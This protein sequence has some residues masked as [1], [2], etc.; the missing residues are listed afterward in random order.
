MSSHDVKAE[1][2]VILKALK[3][4]IRLSHCFGTLSLMNTKEKIQTV[5]FPSIYLKNQSLS[6]LPF[7]YYSS[8]ASLYINLI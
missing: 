1:R 4:S 8:L 6:I 3:V 5:Y 7:C 2:K